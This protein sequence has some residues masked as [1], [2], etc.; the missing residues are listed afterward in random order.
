MKPKEI[1][2]RIKDKGWTQEVFATKL[3][4]SLRTVQNYLNGGKI[5]KNRQKQ[6]D[7]FFSVESI[8][9]KSYT[10][11]E[12]SLKVLKNPDDYHGR[13]VADARN[14]VEGFEAGVK[15]SALNMYKIK[16]LIG[17]GEAL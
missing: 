2:Q 8:P 14:Y 5:P 9:D 1:R 16:T 11:Y 6:I 10:K 13:D 3:G 12:Q 4:V 15:F 7:L 17:S